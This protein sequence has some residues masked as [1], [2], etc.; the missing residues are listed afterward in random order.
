MFEGIFHHSKSH[1][2]L[3]LSNLVLFPFDLKGLLWF[4]H[5]LSVENDWFI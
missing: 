5:F 1:N 2:V 4:C 3:L